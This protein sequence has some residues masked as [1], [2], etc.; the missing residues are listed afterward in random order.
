MAKENLT[1]VRVQD[2]TCPPEQSQAFLWDSK[3]PGLAL[4][5][6]RSGTKTY[7][8]QAKI[9]GRG[10]DPRISIGSPD[11]W[12][13]PEAREQARLY[14]LMADKGLDPREVQATERSA[15]AAASAEQARIISRESVT[16]GNVWPTYLADRKPMWSEGHYDN[17]V[18]LSAKGGKEKKRGKG[19]TVRG[20]LHALMDVLLSELTGDRIA[21]WLTQ[22]VGTRATSAAQS[23]R[24]LRA[25]IRWA[26]DIPAYRGL[27]PSGSY[28]SRKVRDVTPKSGTKIGDCL[29]REQLELWFKGVQS[30]DNKIRAAYLQA[31]LLTGARRTELTELTWDNVDFEWKTMLIGDKVEGTRTIPL[32]PYLSHLL[33]MLP[34]RN[35]W[36][37]S[38]PQSKSGHIEEPK[39]AQRRALES[40]GL[41]HITI[42]GLRRS[43][44]TLAEWLDVPVGVVAQINGHKPSALAERHYKRRPID[45]L[46]LWHVKIE[47]WMLEEAKVTW[48]QSN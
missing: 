4:R 31:L 44:G 20:P 32:T 29:Q 2:F 42:H 46:R 41:P 5:A 9:T 10:I 22:E 36:V 13:L 25:F 38:S 1:A 19:L 15:K 14:K 18:N 45:M 30:L 43:F 35:K 7:I 27:V 23:F 6:T 8:F 24:I 12:R 39:D 21:E 47:T 37:F 3:T 17:H 11:T 28:S 34:H 48:N 16:L 33:T 26:D 40:V